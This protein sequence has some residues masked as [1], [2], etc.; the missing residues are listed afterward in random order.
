M[1]KRPNCVVIIDSISSFIARDLDEEVR[2]DYRPGVLRYCQLL[3]KMSSIVPKQRAIIIMITHFIANTGGME[4][5][6]SRWRRKGSLSSRHD[7]GNC[8]V[9]A[10]K[11][12]MMADKLDKHYTGK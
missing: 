8:L 2:G 6:S 11:E 10:W 5:E 3:Q 7:T 9:Q 4:K 1:V 12:R